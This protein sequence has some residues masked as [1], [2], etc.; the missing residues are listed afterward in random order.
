MYSDFLIQVLVFDKVSIIM[1]KVIIT[2]NTK[3]HIRFYNYYLMDWPIDILSPKKRDKDSNSFV[4]DKGGNWYI[5]NEDDIRAQMRIEEIKA[6]VLRKDR[7]DYF[8]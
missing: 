5:E 7:H 8:K 2:A 4:Y 3:P 6:N 1:R